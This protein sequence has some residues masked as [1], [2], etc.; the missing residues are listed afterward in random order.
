[1]KR[2]RKDVGTTQKF[3]LLSFTRDKGEPVLNDAAIRAAMIDER[4]RPISKDEF[5]V[6]YHEVLGGRKP[7]ICIAMFGNTARGPA[8][9][10]SFAGVPY[11]NT[12]GEIEVIQNWTRGNTGDQWDDGWE[13]LLVPAVV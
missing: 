1:M 2:M 11:L 13:F 3:V 6:F 4:L 5:I 7:E 10:G 8:E 9:S 12:D